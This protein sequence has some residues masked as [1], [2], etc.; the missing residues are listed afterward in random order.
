VGRTS[1]AWWLVV[2]ALVMSACASPGNVTDEGADEG[3]GQE[4]REGNGQES[5]ESNGEASGEGTTDPVRIGFLGELS[6]P[7]SIWGVSARD[8]MRL[9]VEDLNADGGIDGRPIELVERDT[10]G[11]PEEGVTALRELI[12]RRGVV[13]AG[14]LVSSDVALAVSRVA[15]EEAVPLFL[16]MA[17]S[18]RILT[19]DSRMT[20]RTCLP[21]ASVVVEPFV[22]YIEEAGL[23]RI[24]AIVADY[25]WGRAVEEALRGAFDGRDDLAFQVEVAPVQ[26]REFTS[27]L[28]RF[29]DPQ[30]I[31][32]TGHPP[33]AL[34]LTRQAGE[35]GLDT[36]VTGS[37]SPAA[38]VM[39]EI[40]SG[41]YDRYLDIS[42]TDHDDPDYHAL[43][44]RYHE[45]FGT[46]MED[47]A[48]AGYGQVL[49]VAEAIEATGET[50]PEAIAEYLRGA[51]F[52]LPG[53][54][55]DLRWTS[56]GDLHDA[57]P[58]LTLLREQA[59]P[60]GVNP[61]ARWYPEAV[62]RSPPLP[63]GG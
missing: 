56:N 62:F 2:A 16:V 1:T 51:T 59:P 29:D 46:F 50:D 61:D 48:V 35:L 28:R 5:G 49:M 60:S 63:P 39:E 18:D 43:A 37:N 3:T 32:A 10:Q 4:S 8:G 45:R 42:C 22:S 41:A 12:E 13:A 21:A 15:E 38:A 55:W 52:D 58:H 31:V 19:P 34:P 20:F 53:Y 57:T 33:G 9:A 24:A 27:Y 36:I 44:E 7:F 54:A 40:G 17:G 11:V 25:E 6:G 30:V 14:G 47:D 23:T 26:E